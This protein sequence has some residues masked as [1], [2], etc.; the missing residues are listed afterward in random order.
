MTQSDSLQ[1]AEPGPPGLLILW[2]PPRCRSTAFLRMM[3]QRGDFQIVHEPF[4][5]LKDFGESEVDGVACTDE[6]SLM[7]A[8][9]AAGA[10]RAV[11]VKDTTDFHYPGVL[12]AED[13]LLG[14]THSVIIRDPREAIA[15]HYR[16]N[17]RLTRDEIGFAW[18][19]EIYEAVAATGGKVAVLDSDDL[20]DHPEQT[21]RAYC[22]QVGIPF[23]PEAL[24]WSA[25]ALPSWEQTMRWHT[26]AAASTKLYRVSTMPAP[27]LSDDPVLG[28]FFR[29]HFPHYQWLRERRLKIAEDA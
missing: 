13:F 6:R 27:D 20:V 23:L 7:D 10:N 22:E 21:V 29:F 17:P 15:S 26:E 25:G 14:A 28:G 1:P 5:R 16:L 3:H 9:L 8:L 2:S 24:S 19:R 4:S 18:V 12:A 11:F